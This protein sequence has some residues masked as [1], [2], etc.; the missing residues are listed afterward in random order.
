MC[1]FPPGCD[2]PAL[3]QEGEITLVW[4][5]KKTVT[6]ISQHSNVHILACMFTQSCLTLCGPRA[7]AHQA[8]L[9]VGF[10]SQEYQSSVPFPTPGDLPDT[11]IEPASPAY[12]AL[13]THSLTAESPG[14]PCTYSQTLI[15]SYSHLNTHT[16]ICSEERYWC[17]GG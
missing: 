16:Y 11:E 17:P 8:P 13:Q 10:P 7:I 4:T 9:S 2:V 15:Y 6:L 14:K 5:S 12:P 3:R 1:L